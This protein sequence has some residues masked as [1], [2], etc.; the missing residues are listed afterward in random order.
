VR[1]LVTDWRRR[2]VRS[3]LKRKVPLGVL[4]RNFGLSGVPALSRWVKTHFGLPP[5]ALRR[6]LREAETLDALRH[7]GR[8]ERVSEG[9]LTENVKADRR[10]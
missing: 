5:V 1:D 10:R 8:G 2:G 6:L 9:A 7:K 4:A 3:G